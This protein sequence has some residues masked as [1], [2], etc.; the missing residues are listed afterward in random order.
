MAK[1]TNKELVDVIT[2]GFQ[3]DSEL[4]YRQETSD[5]IDID[6]VPDVF[7]MDM[8]DYQ[9]NLSRVEDWVNSFLPGQVSHIDTSAIDDEFAKLFDQHDEKGTQ[10]CELIERAAVEGQ[11]HNFLRQSARSLSSHMADGAALLVY[12]LHALV[13]IG[14]MQ[15][16]ET[17]GK[18]GKVSHQPRRSSHP[19]V[20]PDLPDDESSEADLPPRL[21]FFIKE[22]YWK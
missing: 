11:P 3:Q 7:N 4:L 12:W 17:G 14:A 20:S 15:I 8:E 13:Q 16:F 6:L 19:E 10:E 21:E 9:G 22:T 2:K 1:A 5:H 18:V